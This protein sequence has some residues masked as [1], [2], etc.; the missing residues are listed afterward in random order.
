MSYNQY[1]NMSTSEKDKL[2]DGLNFQSTLNQFNQ[3]QQSRSSTLKRIA[4]SEGQRFGENTDDEYNSEQ[5]QFP[6]SNKHKRTHYH[7]DRDDHQ[8]QKTTGARTF[9]NSNQNNS[10]QRRQPSTT[11]SLNQNMNSSNEILWRI[12]KHAL[13]YASEYHYSPFKLECQPK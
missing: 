4:T 3:Q 10:N 11:N 7:N 5:W 1:N 2:C 12:S 9:I 6:T 13:D 8:Q